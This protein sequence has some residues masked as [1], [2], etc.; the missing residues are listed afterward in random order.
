MPEPSSGISDPRSAPVSSTLRVHQLLQRGEPAQ[1]TGLTVR[2]RITHRLPPLPPVDCCL[3]TD[4]PLFPLPLS[5]ASPALLRFKLN[6]A[7]RLLCI[8]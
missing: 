1:R 3:L 6:Y 4:L 8:G 5:P 2:R 7:Y